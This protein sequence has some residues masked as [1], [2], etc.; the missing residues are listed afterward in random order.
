MFLCHV[1]QQIRIYSIIDKPE[2]S[3]YGRFQIFNIIGNFGGV[4][5]CKVPELYTA[6]E[7]GYIA[8]KVFIFFQKA[9]NA[10]IKK[11]GRTGS[12]RVRLNKT[13]R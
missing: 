10:P 7:E 13:G 5:F 3:K 6:W 2:I 11:S 9:A 1:F 8:V 12:V 4:I